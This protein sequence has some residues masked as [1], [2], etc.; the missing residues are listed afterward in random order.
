VII[1]SKL[2]KVKIFESREGY[3]DREGGRQRT[4]ASTPTIE[5]QIEQ[6][7]DETKCLIV[8]TGPVSLHTQTVMDISDVPFDEMPESA[9]PSSSVEYVQIET[10]ILA[11][12][13]VPPVTQKEG[14]YGEQ[15]TG[16]DQQEL[17]GADEPTQPP[18]TSKAPAISDGGLGQRG[19]LRVPRVPTAAE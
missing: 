8:G 19:G 6:W 12:T 1:P 11:V 9:M 17:A 14:V 18:S 7:V 5:Q 16:A 15:R 10:R 4:P 3:V 13:Y 2:Y